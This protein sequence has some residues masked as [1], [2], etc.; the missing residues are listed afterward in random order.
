MRRL[1][2]CIAALAAAM[3]LPLAAQAPMAQSLRPAAVDAA[4]ARVIVKYRAN[5]EMMKKQAMTATGR[6]N[7]QA[8]GLGDQDRRALAAGAGQFPTAP[9]SSLASGPS[10]PAWRLGSV[11]WPTSS[12]RWSTSASTS[13][14]CPTI[15][16]MPAV[17]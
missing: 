15:R 16:S 13:S 10:R 7:L 6:R 17:P 4:R 2:Q 5:S 9:T 14:P 11:P 8:Q 3:L 1:N 12:T